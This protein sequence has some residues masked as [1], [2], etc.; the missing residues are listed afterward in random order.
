MI[1]PIIMMSSSDHNVY[2]VMKIIITS[3]KAAIDCG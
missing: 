2:I 3:K 1:I